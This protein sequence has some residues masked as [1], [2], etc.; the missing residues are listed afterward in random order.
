MSD[1]QLQYSEKAKL[2]QADDPSKGGALAGG[3]TILK[4]A[5]V[6]QRETEGAIVGGNITGAKF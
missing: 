1:F 5:Y 4:E 2:G 3:V 6:Y